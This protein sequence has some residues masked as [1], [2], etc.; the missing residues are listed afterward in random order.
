MRSQ[1]VSD[2]LAVDS[3]GAP[4]PPRQF[5][6]DN[7]AARCSRQK[8]SSLVR[9]AVDAKG[10]WAARFPQFGKHAP[11]SHQATQNSTP[12]SFNGGDCVCRIGR[13]PPGRTT[14]LEN[15]GSG[16]GFSIRATIV[17]GMSV[18]M[19]DIPVRTDAPEVGAVDPVACVLAPPPPLLL[20]VR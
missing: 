10:T 14:I 11:H 5:P 1:G 9:S 19:D 13:N 20:G 6:P 18:V 2:V 12:A 4:W 15:S 16:L 8:V 3:A 7:G 17:R